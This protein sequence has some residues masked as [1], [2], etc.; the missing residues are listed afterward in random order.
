MSSQL[1][2][3]LN[4]RFSGDSIGQGVIQGGAASRLRVVRLTLVEVGTFSVICVLS[5]FRVMF[6][7]KFSNTYIV[8][9]TNPFFAYAS[10]LP[11][12]M[13][14]EGRSVL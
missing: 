7:H 1:I 14:T 5:A 12:S 4:D 13:V 6:M 3:S 11:L 10:L 2:L 9:S 8:I